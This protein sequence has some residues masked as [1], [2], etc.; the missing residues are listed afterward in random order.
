MGGDSFTS[1][2]TY[3]D[4]SVWVPNGSSKVSIHHPLGGLIGTPWKVSV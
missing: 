1:T 3:L 2:L 4:R